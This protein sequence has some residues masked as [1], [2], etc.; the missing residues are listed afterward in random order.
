MWKLLQNT[1]EED[2]QDLYLGTNDIFRPDLKQ[3]R[4]SLFEIRSYFIEKDGQSIAPT[5]LR[6]PLAQVKERLLEHIENHAYDFVFDH[7]T[8][9]VVDLPN[10][11][12]GPCFMFLSHSLAVTLDFYTSPRPSNA[13]CDV[14]LALPTQS[15]IVLSLV[16]GNED[17][18]EAVTYS[19]SVARGV[20]ETLSRFTDED[21]NSI[22]GVIPISLLEDTVGFKN[23]LKKL[24]NESS[25]FV[26][27]DSL[28]MTPSRYEKVLTAFWAGVAETKSVLKAESGDTDGDYLRFLTKEQCIIL[29]ENINSKDVEVKCMPGS[30]ATTLMLEVARRLNRLGDTLL[31]CR[32]RQERD[33]LRSVYPSAVAAEDL[34]MVDMSSCVNIVDETNTVMEQTSGHNWRFTT[35]PTAV[36]ELKSQLLEVE[37]QNTT[38]EDEQDLYLGTNDIFRPDLKQIGNSLFEIRSYFIE[39]D[40]Q[41]IAPTKLRT[42]L[43]QVKERLLEH[44]ENHAYDFVFDHLTNEVVDLPNPK[45]G[46]CFM[47]L[48]HSLAVALDFYTSPRP[49][50]AVCDVFLALPTQ[51]VIVLSL[52]D[53]NED[54]PE[55]VTYSLSVARGVIETLSRFTDE[56][57]NSIHGVIPISL[58]EDTVGFK[59]R[60]KKLANESSHFVTN[61]SLVMTPSRYE[62][63]LTAFWAGVAETKSVLKAERGDTDG[64]Y[65]RF[66]T[67]EQCIILVENIN[68]KDVEVKCMPGSGATTLM[69][70]VARRLNRL[71]DTLLVCRSRQ[72]RDRLRSVYPSAVAAEDLSMVDMSSCVNIVDE[73]NTVM[74]QT[75]GHNWRFTTYPA[76]VKELK[77]QPLEPEIVDE[78]NT[79]MEQTSGHNWRFTTYLT[80]IKELKSQIF[81]AEM[82]IEGMEKQID[83]LSDESW[84]ERIE[85]LLRDFSVLK[86]L[87]FKLG[88]TGPMPYAQEVRHTLEYKP[89]LLTASKGQYAS[90]GGFKQLSVTQEAWLSDLHDGLRQRK[91]LAPLL[92]SVIIQEKTDQFYQDV[93]NVLLREALEIKTHAESTGSKHIVAMIGHVQSPD[94]QQQMEMFHIEPENARKESEIPSV[95]KEGSQI[96]DLETEVQNTDA[97]DLESRR[98]EIEKV[99]QDLNSCLKDRDHRKRQ[100]HELYTVEWQA[101]MGYLARHATVL[102]LLDMEI[103]R[104]GVFQSTPDRHESTIPRRATGVPG[105]SA[106]STPGRGGAGKQTGTSKGKEQRLHISRSTASQSD[107]DGEQRHTRA[108]GLMNQLRQFQQG[109][110]T[111]K[112][113]CAITMKI[114]REDEQQLMELN[115]NN[116]CLEKDY[117]SSV[118]VVGL[119]RRPLL[120]SCPKLHLDAARANTDWCHVTT[121]GQL[122]NSPPDT[123]DVGQNRLQKYRGTC[124]SPIPLPPSS[125]TLTPLPTIPRYWETET[126]VRVDDEL[127]PTVLEMG[128][129]EA[130]RVDSGWYVSVQRR[131]WC[132]RVERCVRHGERICTTVCREGEWGECHQNTMSLTPGTQAT[133]HYGVVLDVGRGRVAF[134]DLDRQVVVVKYNV[135]FSEPL[136]PMFGVGSRYSGHTT[137]MSLISGEDID[138]TDTKKTLIYQALE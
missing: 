17:C 12:T 8:N 114:I 29:V 120:V 30:G 46:P 34:S 71:G 64:D 87:S 37:M 109:R 108:P 100:L 2:E 84:K 6:T 138:M 7:L 72:E 95:R 130:G 124:S 33:R 90:F 60:L 88:S 26:T 81:D 40:G 43:A 111:E 123:R 102:S 117:G 65:L 106:V 31:V 1:T 101:V 10:P 89:S 82:E 41:S 59:N 11:K 39:K 5:K 129:C 92:R 126:W 115:A 13:V 91:N 133:L 56:D 67:K 131:S 36:K 4:N 53:G 86:I 15:V 23:R 9:E 14:F 77:S 57:V 32:S 113:L 107:N 52:V 116:D 61:D 96:N 74:E 42:P 70:E 93:K 28:V 69:L 112:H 38:E 44:I 98:S 16:D 132:V 94:I 27:N 22:H 50:N 66:L 104:F 125:S 51:S 18:P 24:A 118:H 137:S 20:I 75:S 135:E 119:T 79:V 73:T 55:A 45:T 121:D 127:Y 21:V 68:S 110:L 49:S 128:L 35:Y 54:C 103:P 19:M 136:V 25:H 97:K 80:G 105:T 76:A 63:V 99:N 83:A 85:E 47:F 58:L 78:T 122:V 62:K 3:I 48:S 134:I